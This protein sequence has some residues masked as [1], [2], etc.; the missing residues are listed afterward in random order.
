ML[1]HKPAA[2]PAAPPALSGA[3]AA[4]AAAAAGDAGGVQEFDERE[5]WREGEVTELQRNHARPQHAVSGYQRVALYYQRVVLYHQRV[6]LYTPYRGLPPP[7][8]SATRRG[9]GYAFIIQTPCKR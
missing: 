9:R 1:E 7:L 3:A 8:L 4:A 5:G 2:P 6:A